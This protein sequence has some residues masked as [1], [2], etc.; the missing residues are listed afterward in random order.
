MA[1]LVAEVS[2][3]PR[4]DNAYTGLAETVEAAKLKANTMVRDHLVRAQLAD[5]DEGLHDRALE[6]WDETTA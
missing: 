6:L 4:C 2:F 3:C 1:S 5:L